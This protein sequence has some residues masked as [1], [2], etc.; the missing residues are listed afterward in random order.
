[1]MKGMRPDCNRRMININGNQFFFN[2]MLALCSIAILPVTSVS[3][4]SGVN[5]LV[6][7]NAADADSIRIGDYYAS[8]RS[9]PARGGWM[10][11]GASSRRLP[12]HE[13]TVAESACITRSGDTDRS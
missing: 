7:T 9:V 3:A 12:R 8:H 6:V 4:Q 1:M 11:S 2:L 10:E 13:A 5:V